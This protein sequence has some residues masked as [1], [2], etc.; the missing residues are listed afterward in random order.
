MDSV[1]EYVGGGTVGFFRKRWSERSTRVQLLQLVSLAVSLG[2]GLPVEALAGI[3]AAVAGLGA[4]A[5]DK[6]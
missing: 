4:L 1:N 5:P 2:T 6:N 3:V